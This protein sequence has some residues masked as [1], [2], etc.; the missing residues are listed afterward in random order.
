[1]GV[2]MDFRVMVI[3][4]YIFCTLSAIGVSFYMFSR[5]EPATIFEKTEFVRQC[6]ILY[7]LRT[8]SPPIIAKIIFDRC[9]CIKERLFPKYRYSEALRINTLTYEKME[10]NLV[11]CYE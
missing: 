5:K 4:L 9:D 2:N 7:N 6:T 3:N 10:G 8:D 11:E 1:M